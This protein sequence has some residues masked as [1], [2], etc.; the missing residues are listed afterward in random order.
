MINIY[1]V[2][3]VINYQIGYINIIIS[4]NSVKKFINMGFNGIG[5]VM[6]YNYFFYLDKIL[7]L[8]YFVF[9]DW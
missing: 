5:L 1:E 7:G 4:V 8:R 6:G 2:R 3:E 9:L